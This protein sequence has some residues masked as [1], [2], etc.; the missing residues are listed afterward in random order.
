MCEAVVVPAKPEKVTFTSKVLAASLKVTKAAPVPGEALGGLSFAP[1]RKASYSNK[2][3]CADPQTRSNRNEIIALIWLMCM[4]QT[5][6]Q[7]SCHS[8]ISYGALS[9]TAGV[10]EVNH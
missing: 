10:S 3:A 8:P 9:A 1:V 7:I 5:R 2:V 6:K 4:S